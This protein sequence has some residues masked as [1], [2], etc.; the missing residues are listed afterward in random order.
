MSKWTTFPQAGEFKFDVSRVKQDW[1]RLHAGDAEP[2][3]KDPLVLQAW[4]LFHSGEFQKSAD[5][6]LK[7]GGAGLNVAN[8]ATCVYATHLETKEKPRLDLYLEVAKR[9]EAMLLADPHGANAHFWHGYALGRYSQGVSVAKALALG[10]SGKVKSALETTIKLQPNH[11]DAHVALGT[12]HAEVIDKVGTLIGGM[13]YG[14]KKDIGLQMF[15]AA[16]KLN[17]ISSSGLVEYA[18]ALVMLEG[19]KKMNEATLLYEQAAAM[20]P[21]DALEWLDVKMAKAEL[22]Y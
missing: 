3:P 22:E 10:L 6:G 19:E 4:A 21:L 1:D 5:V 15:Q 18:N 16:F 11:A 17:P 14:A 12:F 9:A 13:T 2:L 8:K 20:D 7:A